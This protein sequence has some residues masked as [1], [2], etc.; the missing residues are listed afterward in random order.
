[1]YGDMS[2]FPSFPLDI[3]RQDRV[4]LSI[5]DIINHHECRIDLMAPE[6]WRGAHGSQIALQ[7]H[8]KPDGEIRVVLPETKR[9][10]SVRLEQAVELGEPDI[11]PV[12]DHGAVGL[13]FQL[14]LPSEIIDGFGFSLD[15][16]VLIDA[17]VERLSSGALSILTFWMGLALECSALGIALE[18][19]GHSPELEIPPV[20]TF[21]GFEHG[22]DS[23]HVGDGLLYQGK[24]L[25]CIAIVA[26]IAGQRIG[27]KQ[28]GTD[29]QQNS[30]RPGVLHC[31]AIWWEKKKLFRK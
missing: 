18:G 30:Q 7:K 3:S 26:L 16:D 6:R 15:S 19:E 8:L 20:L 25:A 17:Q 1:M 22:T 13:A 5:D 24:G 21:L 23:A 11:S 10:E 28:R 9:Q 14:T 27:H 2:F 29:E 12:E 31:I 4:P